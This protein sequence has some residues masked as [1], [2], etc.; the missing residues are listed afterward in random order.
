MPL[1]DPIPSPVANADF[2]TLEWQPLVELVAGSAASPVGR[3]IIFSLVPST[4]ESWIAASTLLAAGLRLL[5][6]EQ[7]SM[8]STGSSTRRS[9]PQNRRLKAQPW[10]PPN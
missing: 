9:L 4:D 8:S 6:E 2:A 10:R 1:L 7:V 3:E 5:L